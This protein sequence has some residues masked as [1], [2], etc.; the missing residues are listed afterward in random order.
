[1]PPVSP[2]VQEEAAPGASAEAEEVA[3]HG[4]TGLDHR[5]LPLILGSSGNQAARW[6][7]YKSAALKELPQ[8]SSDGR[9][10]NPLRR[11][12]P[13]AKVP[14]AVISVRRGR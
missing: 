10:I 14:A 3:R 5:A 11:G 9:F 6:T 4:P 7:G 12:A 2:A 13:N 1:M 8:M